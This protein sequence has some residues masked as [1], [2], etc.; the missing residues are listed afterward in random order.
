MH[1]K[2]GSISM[3]II[4]SCAI[5][6]KYLVILPEYMV[7]YVGNA[8][9]LDILAKCILGTFSLLLVLW[10]YKPFAPMCL[11]DVFRIS[12]GRL[13]DTALRYV[14]IVFF[15]LFNSL[16]FRL[17]IEALSTVMA[18][19]APDEFFAVFILAAVFVAAYSG[20]RAT[21]NLSTVIFPLVP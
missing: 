15:T 18:T 8:A 9:W 7:K 12:L 1:S 6:S 10:L 3:A 14:Y 20:I 5:L 17:L 16:L 11:T 21:T 4:C 13:G 19:T 2:S